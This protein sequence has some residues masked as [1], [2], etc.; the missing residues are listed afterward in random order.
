MPPQDDP[1]V[2]SWLGAVKTPNGDLRIVFNISRREGNLTGTLDSPDQGAFGIP[3]DEVSYMDGAFH[4]AVNTI[5]GIYDGAINDKGILNG[6]WRQGGVRIALRM[7]KTEEKPELVRPQ[8]PE[9][10]YPYREEDVRFLNAEDRIS[11]AGTLLIPEGEGP[12]PAVAFC[13]GSGPQ[14][15]DESVF[16]HKPFWIIADH[17]ARNGIA[18]LRYDD[19]GIGG[20]GGNF[21]TATSAEFARDLESAITFLEGRDE[22]DADRIGA[23]GHSEGAIVVP[24]IANESPGLDFAVLLAPPGVPAEEIITSQSEAIARLNGA[25]ES[26]I[27]ANTALRRQLFAVVLEG[28]SPEA[29]REKMRGIL[30]EVIPDNPAAVDGQIDQLTT[31]WMRSFL[32]YDPRPALASIACPTFALIG[33]LDRQV[34]A[35]VNAPAIEAAFAENPNEDLRLIVVPNANHLF[36]TAETGLPTEYTRIEETISPEVLDDIASWM[37]D[38]VG[39]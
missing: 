2:G 34:L 8:E 13:S 39:S 29:E 21:L 24:M 28:L 25:S 30:E 6:F 12:F 23:I 36:Q 9:P 31:P 4:V 22:I 3:I 10:P 17:L 14:D 18:S 16:G 20:S 5:G 19:R 33:E 32:A 1:A 27:S 7:E 15:R 37:L 11:L 26:D 38:V 35:E